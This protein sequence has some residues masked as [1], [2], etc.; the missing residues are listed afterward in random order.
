MSS[1][2]V[3]RYDAFG[4]LLE[5]IVEIN[6]LT[7]VRTENVVGAL[8]LIIPAGL[9]TYEDISTNQILEVWRYNKGRA[10]LQGETAYFVRDWEI[11]SHGEEH[12]IRFIAYD[13]TWL[14]STR[15]VAYSAGSSQAIMTNQPGDIILH[16][17]IDNFGS[18]AITARR[19]SSLAWQSPYDNVR[20]QV[21]K[22][23][24]WRNVLAVCQELAGASYE[25]NGE[26]LVF[27]VVRT[28]VA[29]FLARV[30]NDCRGEDHGRYSKDV[31]L[32]G[33]VY[34]NLKNP[35]FG[36]YHTGE[37]NYIYAGGQGEEDSR[38]IVEVSDD[39]R[40]NDGY[41]FNRCEGFVDARQM[42][43][44]ESVAS[45]GNAGL[46][47]GRPKQILTGQLIDTPSMRYGVH[48]GFGDILSVE[49]FGYT[50]DCHVRSVKVTVDSNGQES[51]EV[52]LRGLL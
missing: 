48:Y 24:P 21:T 6:K 52:K 17:I 38:M 34:G 33:E 28:G 16:T 36:T 45:E 37:K 14:L 30:Y 2:E 31:R 1:H 10:E 3:R 44:T 18:D 40:I 26:Y 46:A 5:T 41:P 25:N 29:Q 23:F 42:S 9:H 8:E 50:V 43:T 7:Y 32:V 11:F 39:A 19:L 20:D 47:E 4:N 22:D 49:A 15:I 27:D 13:A 51:V 35:V 12:L